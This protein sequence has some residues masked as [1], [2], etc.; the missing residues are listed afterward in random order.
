MPFERFLLFE[1]PG[2]DTIITEKQEILDLG[3]TYKSSES[4]RFRKKFF[5]FVF[6]F[7]FECAMRLR[8]LG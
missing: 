3:W 8:S 6:S 5:F 2:S 1:V 4:N 7:A